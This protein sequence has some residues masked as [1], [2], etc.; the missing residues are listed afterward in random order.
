MGQLI[1]PLPPLAELERI[2]AKI[3]KLFSE[4]DAGLESL[5]TAQQQL[6]LYRQSILNWAFN[7][8]LTNA[9]N[10]GELPLGWKLVKISEIAE[11][12]LGRQRS[13]QKA[14]GEDMCL[15]LRAANVTWDKLN[16][17]DVKSMNFS[18]K[19]QEIYRLKKGNILLSEASGSVSEVGKPAIWND[20]ISNC[21][22]QNTLIR[23]RPY[24]LESSKFL[25]LRF[26]FDAKVEN[27]RKI[28]KGVGIHH[29]GAAGLFTLGLIP[30]QL[31]TG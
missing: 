8:K 2:V 4:L 6:K 1:L 5:K 25:H 16:L 10:D 12:R 30:R 13:P 18:L 21:C 9:V 28:A 15:Y 14:Y 31:A 24:N 17:P 29:L 19:E 7:G 3:E 22:L 26:Y 23:V 27:F 11:V 20:E